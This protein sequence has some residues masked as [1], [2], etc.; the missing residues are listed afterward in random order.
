MEFIT[1][2]VLPIYN[3]LSSEGKIVVN[4]IGIVVAVT[5]SRYFFDPN[6]NKP[7]INAAEP[8]NTVDESTIIP[9]MLVT[10]AALGGAVWIIIK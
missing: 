9:M 10:L 1:K 5:V 7:G 8:G 3:D 6:Y 2:E 4:L